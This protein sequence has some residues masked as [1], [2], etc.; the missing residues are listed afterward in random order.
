MNF[1][2][3]INR[4]NLF[5]QQFLSP[6]RFPWVIGFAVLMLLATFLGPLGLLLMVIGLIGVVVYAKDSIK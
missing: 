3:F 5:L 1:D 6:S 4:A 2:D